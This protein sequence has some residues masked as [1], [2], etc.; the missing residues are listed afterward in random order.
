[1]LANHAQQLVVQAA[2]IP[3]HIAAHRLLQSTVCRTCVRQADG[4]NLAS[5]CVQHDVW[6]LMVAGDAGDCL[7]GLMYLT[8]VIR[9]QCHPNVQHATM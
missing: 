8:H 5:P 1:M 9:D 4:A 3:G 7:F 6:A 2:Y